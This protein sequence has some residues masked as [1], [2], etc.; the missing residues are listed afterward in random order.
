MKFEQIQLLLESV[1]KHGRG[2]RGVISLSL[3]TGIPQFGIRRFVGKHDDC[4]MYV[5]GKVVLN[6]FGVHKGSVSDMLAHFREQNRKRTNCFWYF[7]CIFI[8][9]NLLLF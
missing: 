2:G 1:E 5:N 3:E 7:L 4:V 6:R 8:V 9:F